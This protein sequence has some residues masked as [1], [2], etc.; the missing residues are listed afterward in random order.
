VDHRREYKKVD[1][2]QHAS[3]GKTG[4]RETY[5]TKLN[6]EGIKKGFDYAI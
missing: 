6:H 4:V 5:P 2:K 3:A 1:G